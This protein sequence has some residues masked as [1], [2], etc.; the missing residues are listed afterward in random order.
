[1]CKFFVI[2]ISQEHTSWLNPPNI[3]HIYK[4]VAIIDTISHSSFNYDSL[5]RIASFVLIVPLNT[6]YN[7]IYPSPSLSIIYTLLTFNKSITLYLYSPI[8]HMCHR[9]LLQC[10]KHTTPSVLRPLN[11]WWEKTRSHFGGNL[12]NCLAAHMSTNYEAR[13]VWGSWCPAPSWVMFFIHS[14]S[15]FGFKPIYDSNL[16]IWIWLDLPFGL[17]NRG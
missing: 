1:M 6:W 14:F 13:H 16:S 9:G 15:I 4:I 5:R 2:I 12:W 11:F 8:L 3:F 10:V 17:P 7:Y